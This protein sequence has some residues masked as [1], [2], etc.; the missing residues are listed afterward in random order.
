[1]RSILSNTLIVLLII[2]GYNFAD[3]SSVLTLNAD[4]L[5][6]KNLFYLSGKWSYHSGDNGE[7]ADTDFDESSWESVDYKILTDLNFDS[8]WNGIGWFRKW[9][10]VDSSLVNRILGLRIRYVGAYELYL[11]GNKLFSAGKSSSDIEE[12]VAIKDYRI[13]AF[14]FISPD[15]NL[16]AIKFSN[17]DREFFDRTT[18]HPGVTIELGDYDQLS[19]G[20]WERDRS[21]IV[22][23]TILISIALILA[24]I[25]MFL[26]IFNTKT[27]S[28]LYYVVFLICFALYMFLSLQLSITEIYW[29]SIAVFI[30]LSPIMLTLTILFGST[31]AYSIFSKLP[32]VYPIV[33]LAAV[34]LGLLGFIVYEAWVF[35]LIYAFILIISP[36]TGHKIFRHRKDNLGGEWIIRSGFIFMS[37]A[38]LYQMFLSFGWVPPVFGIYVVYFYGVLGFIISM[39]ILLARDFAVTNKNLELQLEN[40]QL[41]SDRTL[42]QELERKELETNK[43]LL[44]ADNQRKTKELEDARKLQ[45]SMLPQKL[46]DI[47]DLDIAAYMNTA[48]EVGGDYYDFILAKDGTLN[49]AVG[50]ATGHGMRAG[51][52]VASIKSLFAALGGNMMIPDFFK[53][54]T[55]IIKSMNLGNL[56]MSMTILRIKG[57]YLIASSAGM[58]PIMI[59]R[60]KQNKI[61]KIVLKGMPLGAFPNY[62]YLE[63]E[64]ELD[65]GDIIVLMSDGLPELFNDKKEMYGDERIQSVIMD[66]VGKSPQDII[67]ALV[68]AGEN[69]R[70]YASQEDDI[71][72]IVI[73]FL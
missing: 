40:V 58:P 26:F 10:F 15:S 7:W 18:Y 3:N 39:S 13:Q 68:Q 57:N 61:D 16:I 21:S 2:S 24:F 53:R 35:Y 73:K 49:I 43:K 29:D 37:V 60:T 32:K 44:E 14:N 52:M 22:Q 46:P 5:D 59:Y 63:Y 50:D 69:W 20:K 23:L 19:S 17:Y 33:L 6:S 38:G 48:T 64:E 45:L 28:N 47:E 55:E 31:A 65:K 51:T 62:D 27:R 4:S 8:G 72:F 41:L 66:A 36:P 56:F 71:T 25:H 12:D 11:N 42:K 67:N 34:I 54:C 70:G 9:V 1:M 30:R